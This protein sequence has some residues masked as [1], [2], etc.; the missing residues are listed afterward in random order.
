MNCPG[1]LLAYGGHSDLPSDSLNTPLG[2]YN[3][4]CKARFRVR[5]G[6]KDSRECIGV[7]VNIASARD[8]TS[9]TSLQLSS[10]GT[11]EGPLNPNR[12]QA[13]VNISQIIDGHG[14]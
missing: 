3:I 2:A 10:M 11:A 13:T 4:G 12:P 1:V 6:M 14:L 7:S 8:P 5:I 9:L